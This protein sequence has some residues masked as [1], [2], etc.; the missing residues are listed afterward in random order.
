MDDGYRG[1][2]AA[3][4]S[5]GAEIFK[6]DICIGM[7]YIL[8]AFTLLEREEIACNNEPLGHSA[9]KMA[10]ISAGGNAICT[11]LGWAQNS[12]INASTLAS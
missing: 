8:S 1:N 4:S 11:F 10:D 9:A 12:P 3:C 6:F 5:D 7:Y 2:K